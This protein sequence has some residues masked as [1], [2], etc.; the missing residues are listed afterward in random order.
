MDLLNTR[1][2]VLSVEEKTSKNGK[3]IARNLHSFGK[4]RRVNEKR[5]INILSFQK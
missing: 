2:I 4:E 1:I 3:T 5:V